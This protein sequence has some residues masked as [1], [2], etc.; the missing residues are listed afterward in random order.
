MPKKRRGKTKSEAWKNLVKSHKRGP[1]MVKMKREP[2]EEEDEDCETILTQRIQLVVDKGR[3][4]EYVIIN[5]SKTA[6]Q[7]LRLR[8]IRKLLPKQTKQHDLYP[9]FNALDHNAMVTGKIKSIPLRIDTY[10]GPYVC[11]VL[12]YS[13]RI[14]NPKTTIHITNTPEEEEEITKTDEYVKS[15]FT[16]KYHK[17][18]VE[19]EY[20]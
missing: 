1:K 10:C 8:K 15:L 17:Q 2:Q 20:M 18:D 12:V 4:R 6:L 13:G 16:M 9:T 3:Q 5:I 19:V 14:K 11:E 7:K